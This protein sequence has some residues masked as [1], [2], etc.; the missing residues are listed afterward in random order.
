MTTQLSLFEHI[1]LSYL[2]K[3]ELSNSELYELIPEN[4]I[5]TKA[6]SK[7]NEFKRKIRWQQQTMKQLGLLEHV[8]D[9]KATW[10]LTEQGK[11]KLTPLHQVSNTYKMIAFSTDLGVAIWADITT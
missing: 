8:E 5:Q 1:G 6:N 2:D 7:Y 9:K 10:R 11:S 4:L 3:T